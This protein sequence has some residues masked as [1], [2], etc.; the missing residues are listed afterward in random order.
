MASR[1]DLN[2][3]PADLD[4]LRRLGEYYLWASRYPVP[5]NALRSASAEKN[6]LLRLSSSDV[7]LSDDLFDRLMR[8]ALQAA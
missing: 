2:L 6:V 3:T 4:L 5:K 1:L 8:I 7:Q